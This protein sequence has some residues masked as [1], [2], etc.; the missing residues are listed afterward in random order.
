[1]T[2][3]LSPAL[4]L[5]GLRWL[6]PIAA[7]AVLGLLAIAASRLGVWHEL[8]TSGGSLVG[9][10]GALVSALNARVG[11]VWLPMGLVAARVAQV[12]TRAWRTR[13][14]R[15]DTGRSVRPELA[16]LAPLFA[17]LGLFG[18]VW[19]LITAFEALES[20]EFLSRL[21]ALLAGLGAAMT[22]TLVGLGL[23]VTT[24]LLVVVAPAWSWLR[25][26]S[27]REGTSFSLD[28]EPV[29]SGEELDALVAAL[30]ARRPEALCVA[31]ARE[32]PDAERI[33]IRRSLWAALD[34][35]IPRREVAA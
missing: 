23:Q 7:G 31:F 11:P 4:V 22:S 27:S 15:G 30:V 35:E 24:L 26:G 3:W 8:V 17:V 21:P 6:A 1:M 13:A 14:G 29:G 34:A 19:G 25:V 16:Q 28:G 20:G 33:R 12:A 2:T 32:V 5:P 18:T 9:D 10:P